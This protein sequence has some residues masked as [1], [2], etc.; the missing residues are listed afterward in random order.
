MPGA[1]GWFAQVLLP[2]GG[3]RVRQQFQMLGSIWRD[4]S[5]WT[6]ECALDTPIAPISVFFCHAQD[7]RF[8]FSHRAW[9]ALSAVAT[10]IVFLRDQYPYP[11]PG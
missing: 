11:M 5:A 3:I 7:Q 4:F 10:A 6:R 8:E 2:R 1:I 9:S